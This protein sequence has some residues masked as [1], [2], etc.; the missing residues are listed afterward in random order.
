[1][2]ELLAVPVVSSV[3]AVLIIVIFDAN[4]VEDAICFG[5][6]FCEPRHAG[7]V[8]SNSQRRPQHGASFEF[9][10]PTHL[11]RQRSLMMLGACLEA[12]DVPYDK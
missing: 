6:D 4:Y 2:G 1:M 9:A 11:L 12:H 5:G 3:R 7:V 10:R 8:W